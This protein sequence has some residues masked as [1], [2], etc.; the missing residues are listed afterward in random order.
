MR[1]TVESLISYCREN[2]RVCPNP[3]LWKQL[4]EML[5]N[6]TPVGS[7]WKPALPLILG[8]WHYSSDE[9]KVRRLV[10]HIKWAAEHGS[11]ESVS[12]FLRGLAEDDWFHVSD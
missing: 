7:G 11:F 5:P 2:N 12:L 4:G 8:A 9:E 6:R 3:Q 10:E 1:D